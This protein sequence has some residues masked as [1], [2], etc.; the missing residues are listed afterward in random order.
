MKAEK[1]RITISYQNKYVF[2]HILNYS[3]DTMKNNSTQIYF[4]QKTY[5]TLFQES[6]NGFIFRNIVFAT[7]FV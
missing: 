4:W 1:M 3:K 7:L 2:F 6:K 5:S